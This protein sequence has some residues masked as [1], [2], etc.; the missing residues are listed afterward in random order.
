MK[1][2]FLGHVV[3]KSLSCFLIGLAAWEETAAVPR[4]LRLPVRRGA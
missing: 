3:N 2:V 4:Q 1:L